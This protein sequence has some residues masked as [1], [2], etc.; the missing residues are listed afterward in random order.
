MDDAAS[1]NGKVDVP[2]NKVN[3]QKSW[4]QGLDITANANTIHGTI[5]RLFVFSKLSRVSNV[6][7][8]INPT[9]MS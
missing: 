1:S 8:Y 3:H 7:L 9:V 6:K 2:I 5:E 4:N